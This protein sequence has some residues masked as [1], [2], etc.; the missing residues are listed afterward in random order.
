MS[1]IVVG[2]APPAIT[3]GWMRETL[4]PQFA[5]TELV[6]PRISVPFDGFMY[7]VCVIY[8]GS[9]WLIFI[10][11]LFG[12]QTCKPRTRCRSLIRS[13]QLGHNQKAE[14]QFLV[15]GLEHVCF[16]IYIY[17]GNNHP[18][19]VSYFSEGWL[20]HQPGS[21]ASCQPLQPLRYLK[22]VSFPERTPRPFWPQVSFCNSLIFLALLGIY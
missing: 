1:L 4:S 19:W 13:M 9:N 18:S 8:D 2:L 21:I 16:H 17:I 22:V 5:C 11:G 15:G 6:C 7:P 3:E 14:I 10:Q 12:M 20:N